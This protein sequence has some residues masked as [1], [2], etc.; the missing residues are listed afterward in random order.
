MRL[1]NEKYIATITDDGV[2]IGFCE[3]NSSNNFADKN[4]KTG[5]A[6]FTLK[7]EDIKIIPHE[8]AES[9]ADHTCKYQAVSPENVSERNK[10]Q[11]VDV[12]NQIVTE[13]ILDE[14]GLQISS[15]TSNQCISEFGLN[16]ELNFMGK[17]GDCYMRQFLPTSP[18]TSEDGKYMYCL[19]QSPNG[20][21]L[22]AAAQTTCDGWKIKYSPYSAGHFILK[23]QFLAS[24][25]QVYCGS[26]RK[27]IQVTLMCADSKEEAFE[28]LHRLYERS[29]TVNLMS[30]GFEGTAYVKTVA[31]VDRYRVIS[32]SGSVSE[33][34]PDGIITMNEFGFHTVI[35]IKG[36]NQGLNTTVWN[37]GNLVNLFDRS[38]DAIRK[39]YH[40]DANLCEGGCFVWA[41]LV[42]MALHNNRA[43]DSIVREELDIVM[44]K[45]KMVPRRTIVPFPVDGHAAW[46]IYQSD[47]VQ[48]QFFG[49]S[50]LL[51][52]Y[53]VYQEQELL[54][55]A[56]NAL[57]EL[58]ENY[59]RDGMVFN[60]EDYTTVCC[61]MIPLVD[62]VCFLKDRHGPMAEQF[63]EAAEKMAFFLYRRGFSF[64]TE[65]SISELTETEMEDGSI[66][67]T[68]LALL[69][70]CTYIRY[71]E[72][73][74]EFAD[75]V[76]KF[77]RA[78]TILTPDA[79]MQGSSFRWWETIW[80]G[81]G[82]GPA[83]CAGHAWTIWR[84]EA[85]FWDGLLFRNDQALLD[86]WNGFVTNFCKTQKDGTMYS[87]Y[88]ADYIR[89]GGFEWAYET[90]AQLSEGEYGVQYEV[91]HGYPKH[92]DSS[93]SRYA[94]V[95]AAGTWMKTAALLKIDNQLVPIN[96]YQKD[97]KWETKE[98]VEQI[99]ITPQIHRDEV[100][101][102]NLELRVV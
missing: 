46:H 2:L 100:C 88:E 56:V 40:P 4:G 53:K 80:E 44:G 13:Y 38:C 30:G 26:G 83:F 39:P 91:A 87:C 102:K 59:M 99:Y 96:I 81:D 7:T 21:I 54:T 95:R 22:V 49:V 68:A 20:K 84:A 28:L 66:S 45:S 10:I 77:H 47:R 94:W 19:M 74:A 71:D 25:D 75:Q 50:I 1:E 62:M 42:N 33:S 79:R 5:T 37:G 97:G 41:M 12:E 82:Q 9:Y 23:F 14:N 17:K 29:I 35:P 85:L 6:C 72:R 36:A 31:G 86:S 48:E 90:L 89:G 101:L 70:F 3:K 69:Y 43:Y 92:P 58:T 98:N 51:E 76:L 93:L 63:Q 11:C 60:G 64:P 73:Y 27:E 34:G 57:K 8:E 15:K 24:F 18:Y 65:G 32:P 52:A 55:Y 16:L 78:W 67:C 61:P